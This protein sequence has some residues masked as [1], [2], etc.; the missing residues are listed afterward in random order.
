MNK[1]AIIVITIC[2]ILIGILAFAVVEKPQN[3]NFE[4]AGETLKS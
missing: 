2:I 1:Q 3:K 4:E